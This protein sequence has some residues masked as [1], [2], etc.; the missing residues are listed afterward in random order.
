MKFTKA[1]AAFTAAFFPLLSLAQNV[2]FDPQPGAPE[3]RLISLYFP[4]TSLTKHAL[5]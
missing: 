1:A 5:P 2:R 4:S 3:R